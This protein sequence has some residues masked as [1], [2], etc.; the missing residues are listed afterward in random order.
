MPRRTRKAAM[1]VEPERDIYDMLF[2]AFLFIGLGIGIAY[3]QAG[4]G[5][6]IGA[7]VG[8]LARGYSKHGDPQT[9]NMSLG[10]AG[11]IIALIGAYFILLSFALIY[12]L[13]FLYPYNAS[14]P[15][16][17]VGIALLIMFFKKRDE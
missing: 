9:V 13:N 2:L 16:I 17:I 8:I 14:V 15:L 4:S 12:N 3:G 7:G 5:L 1:K 11:Y 10:I 6:L